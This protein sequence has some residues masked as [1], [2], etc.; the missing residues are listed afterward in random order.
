MPMRPVAAALG[1]PPAGDRLYRQVYA[2]S[3]TSVDEVARSLL[4][5]REE[6][7]DELAP[8]IRGGVVR[9]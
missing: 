1:I 7:L 8:M 5:S 9:V 4:R 3:G 6:R 2:G